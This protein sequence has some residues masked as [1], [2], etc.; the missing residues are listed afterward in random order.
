LKIR[1]SVTYVL[2]ILV[3]IVTFYA[4]FNVGNPHSLLRYFIKTDAYDLY[5]AMGGS[6]AVFFLGFLIFYFRQQEG[7]TE[8]LWINRDRIDALRKKGYSDEQIAEDLLGA[9]GMKSGY[10]YK[11]TKKRLVLELSALGIPI[12]RD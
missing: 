2:L 5:I 12:R 6:L 10:R 9:L 8:L 3:G 1:L 4:L 7:F 11:M